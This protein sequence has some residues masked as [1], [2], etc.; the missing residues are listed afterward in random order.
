MVLNILSTLGPLRPRWFLLLRIGQ[1]VV[2]PNDLRVSTH[3]ATPN[4]VYSRIEGSKFMHMLHGVFLKF[5]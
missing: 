2:N 4:D 3:A 1:A 5:Y